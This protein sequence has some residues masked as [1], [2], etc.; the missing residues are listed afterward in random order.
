[1][2]DGVRRV[3]LGE[4]LVQGELGADGVMVAGGVEYDLVA[5]YG[6]G[7]VIVGVHGGRMCTGQAPAACPCGRAFRC[8]WR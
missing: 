5:G 6:I 8:G 4:E 7:A 3:G 2:T 1:M